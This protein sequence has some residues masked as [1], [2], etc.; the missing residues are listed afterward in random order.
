MIVANINVD[1]FIRCIP[2]TI[3]L[4]RP[5]LIFREVPWHES[6][7]IFMIKYYLSVLLFDV[8]FSKRYIGAQMSSNVRP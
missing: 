4:D 5:Q 2:A 6:V 3:R 1:F 8:V 7:I